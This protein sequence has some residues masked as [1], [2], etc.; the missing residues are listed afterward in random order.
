M[1][2][3]DVVIRDI[4]TFAGRHVIPVRPLTIAVGENS[5]GKSTFLSV[6]SALLDARGFP[7]RPALN[8][9]PFD[10]GGFDNILT[11]IRRRNERPNNFAIGL[12]GVAKD[13]EIQ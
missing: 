6:L 7:F 8:R 13:K 5:S 9:P 1:L 12:S 10:L 2:N 11:S 3:L 4:R